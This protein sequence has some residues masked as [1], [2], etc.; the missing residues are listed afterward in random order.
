MPLIASFLISPL[1]GIIFY[2]VRR[3]K[4]KY[5]EAYLYAG[6]RSVI[7]TLVICYLLALRLYLGPL[8]IA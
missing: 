3:K 6:L 7:I 2:S 8:V 1:L 4:D 5:P